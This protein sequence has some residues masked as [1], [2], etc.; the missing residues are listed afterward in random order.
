RNLNRDLALLGPEKDDPDRKSQVAEKHHL[1][2]VN[3]KIPVPDLRVE[4]ETTDLGLWRKKPPQAS[5]SMVVRKTHRVCA[6][7]STNAKSPHG[8]SRYEYRP[9]PSR[10][11]KSPRLHRSGSPLSLHRSDAFRLLC[12]AS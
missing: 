4:Y 2:L 11:S 5:R 9:S 3:G 8:S 6:A 10:R 1:Q 12:G 7:F